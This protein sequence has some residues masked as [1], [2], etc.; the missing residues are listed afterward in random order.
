MQVKL[1][2]AVLFLFLIGVTLPVEEK[3]ASETD[4]YPSVEVPIVS[5]GYNIQRIIDH[6][7]GTKSVAYYVQVEYP[8]NDIIEFYDQKFKEIGWRVAHGKV[9]RQW[10]YFI[11][12]TIGGNPRVRQ[13]LALWVNPQLQAEAFFAL[14]YIREGGNWGKELHVLCQIQP[15]LDTTRLEEFLK[16]LRASDEYMR[17]MKLLDS[18][19]TANGEVDIDKALRENRDN[20]YLR[21]Y[22]RIV[23]EMGLES[24]PK[25][26][27][28]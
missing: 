5:S 15:L 2:S 1:V 11:D 9:K 25:R 17:F 16:R 12:G 24:K 14:R 28:K 27:S 7:R 26:L 8:A 23:D 4:P 18:Y 20:I 19:R 3:A 10:E 21:Q 13:Y 6:P 22:K